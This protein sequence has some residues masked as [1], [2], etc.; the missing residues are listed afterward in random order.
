MYI[1][2]DDT[3]NTHSID[4]RPLIRFFHKAILSFTIAQT[5][6]QKPSQTQRRPNTD[7][8]ELGYE[9]FLRS[10]ARPP[11]AKR[12]KV[13]GSGTSETLSK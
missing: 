1:G 13:A 5:I 11:A 7:L 3:I 2:T 10:M 6:S 8:D 4:D 12:T 9:R